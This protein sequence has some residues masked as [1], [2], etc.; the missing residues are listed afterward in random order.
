VVGRNPSTALRTLVRGRSDVTITGR[1]DDV[2]PYIDE[3]A[4]FIVPIRI[5]GG[6]RLKIYEA[7]AMEKPVVSTTIGAEGLPVTDGIDIL[8]ADDPKNFAA[9]VVRLLGDKGLAQALGAQAA[10]KV[11][12]QFGWDRVAA[13][14]S[15]LCESAIHSH[16]G[17]DRRGA[18]LS[19]AAHAPRT[20]VS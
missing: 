17:D 19:H 14:F 2:R 6:T 10:G 15:E 13:R 12:D 1:V 16:L 5:G 7:M 3:A 4:C 11:R 9:A 18:P 20:E 8:L